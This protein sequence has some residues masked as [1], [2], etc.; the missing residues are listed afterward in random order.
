MAREYVIQH[1]KNTLVATVRGI[2]VTETPI[3]VA[4]AS[5][6]DSG[7]DRFCFRTLKIIAATKMEVKKETHVEGEN[8]RMMLVQQG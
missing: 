3:T 7:K 4:Q 5:E 2:L 8:T 6:R 1:I